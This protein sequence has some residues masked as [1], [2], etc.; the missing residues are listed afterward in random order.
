MSNWKNTKKPASSK[1]SMGN[2]KGGVEGERPRLTK[3][4]RWQAIWELAKGDA[5]LVAAI[6]NAIKIAEE[7]E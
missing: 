2:K 4:E 1:Q 5:H 6:L 3:Q 7:N